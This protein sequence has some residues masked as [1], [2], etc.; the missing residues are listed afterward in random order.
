[1]EDAEKQSKEGSNSSTS[2]ANP[3]NV[4]QSDHAP[5][6]SAHAELEIFLDNGIKFR[7]LW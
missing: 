6:G 5:K 1:M 3:K 2:E 4:P 7:P